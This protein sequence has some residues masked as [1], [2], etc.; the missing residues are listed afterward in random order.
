MDQQSIFI[1]LLEVPSEQFNEFILKP[2]QSLTGIGVFVNVIDAFDECDNR[3]SI[4]DILS[5][6]EFPENVYFI[7]TTRPEEDIIAKLQNCPHVLLQDINKLTEYSIYKDIKSYIH[8][9]LTISHLTFSETEIEQLT[10]KADGLFQ[11]AATACSH[12]AECKAGADSKNRF[13]SVLSFHPG[14]DSLYTAVLKDKISGDPKEAKSVMA[15]LAKIIAAI[16]PLSIHLL[17]ALCL[18]SDEQQ[19]VEKDIPLLGAVFTVHGSNV[20]QPIH[21]SF[22]DYLTDQARSGP[23]FVD[24]NQGHQD[25]AYAAFETMK[26]ELH[27]NICQI[28]SSY[29]LNT[30]L[31]QEQINIISPALFYSCCF[32]SEHLRMQKAIMNFQN[33]V[34]Y[35]LKNQF[36]FWLEVLSAKK[37]YSVAIPAMEFLS[38]QVVSHL[39]HYI[40]R[41]YCLFVKLNNL[42]RVDQLRF[43]G[44]CGRCKYIHPN[45]YISTLVSNTT[46]LS[47]STGTFTQQFR[48][49]QTLYS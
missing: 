33:S 44:I 7:I 49:T 37:A 1:F 36:L 20:I 38:G 42:E 21:T 39:L 18:N 34:T 12:I 27:F 30:S 46:Y 41:Y 10:H 14:L 19:V 28:K 32:W 5:K 23:Y 8:H 43:S 13:N 6:G 31:T 22:R 9:Q 3:S 26:N 11:W 17:K 16:E 48:S 2:M 24:I 4:L 35:F 47:V 45:I 40:D 29:L 15:V 25:L